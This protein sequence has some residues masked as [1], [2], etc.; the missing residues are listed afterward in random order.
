MPH[1]PAPWGRDADTVEKLVIEEEFAEHRVKAPNLGITGWV[2]L[3]IAQ[4]GTPEQARRWVADALHGRTIWCQLFSEP[5]AGSAAAAISTRGVRDEGG[6]RVSG[7]KVW[8]SA[9]QW[10]QWG[11]ATVRTDSSGSKHSGVTMMA[12]DLSAP[13]V[14]IRPRAS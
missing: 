4:H 6:W 2:A 5:G 8:T 14:T 7:A 10:S 12:I 3:T 9:A 1:W 13:G 11:F